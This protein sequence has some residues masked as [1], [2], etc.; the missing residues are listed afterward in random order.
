MAAP[1]L[2]GAALGAAFAV[3]GAA[4]G[5][6]LAAAAAVG[7]AVAAVHAATSVAVARR[8]PAA[9]DGDGVAPATP[10]GSMA[11]AVAPTAVDGELPPAT[12]TVP[13]NAASLRRE[14]DYWTI[15]FQGATFRLKDAKGVGYLRRLLAHPGQ[16]LHAMDLVVGGSDRSPGR[17]QPGDPDALR[18]GAEDAG[19]MLD[20]QAKAA[21]R[22]RLVELREEAE[23]AR[24]WG[25]A[26][27]EER[28]EAEI[29]VLAQELSRAV[30]LDGRDRKAASASE[31]ARVNVTRAVK[32]AI[33][34]ISEH[35]A[36]LGHHLA[37]TVHTG[38]FCSYRP[39]PE[40]GPTWDL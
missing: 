38:T 34:R 24:Q 1:G 15:S 5:L 33:D 31:R 27:R 7:L 35:D 39:D 37:S 3:A 40:S 16:E 22:Q 28:A 14:G 18:L 11:T 6:P 17:G 12:P 21:Y 26:E 13:A 19:A 32:S 30:G 25:D 23:E 4:I 2:L 36:R 29:A 8:W 20:P 10:G 9:A